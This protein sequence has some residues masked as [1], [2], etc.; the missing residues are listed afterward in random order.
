VRLDPAEIPAL[1]LPAALVDRYQ[2]VIARTPE[3]RGAAPGTLSYHAGEARLLVGA[4]EAAR[5]EQD[6]L[7]RRLLAELRAAGAELTPEPARCVAVLATSLELVAGHAPAAAGQGTT[8][9]VLELASAAIRARLPNS[10]LGVDGGPVDQEAPAPAQIAL[11][12]VQFAANAA[13][14]EGARTLRLRIGIGPTFFVEWPSERTTSVPTAG[15]HHSRLRQRWGLG[16]VRMVAD[17]LGATALPPAPTEPGW[18]GACLSLGSRRLTLPLAQ[19]VGGAVRRATQ[20]WEQEAA[21]EVPE[22][23]EVLVRD[24]G[25][26]LAAAAGAPGTIARGELFAARCAGGA[27]W[28][29]L[30]PE[31]GAERARD[32]LR[33]LDHERA[34]WDLP[35]A[36]AIRVHALISLLGT[37][38]GEP[39]AA[40]APAAFE[41]DLPRACA[42][43]GVP[44][45]RVGPV[46][47]CPDPRVVAFLLGELGGELVADGAGMSLIPGAGAAANPLVRLLDPSFTGRVL[48][49]G[50]PR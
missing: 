29:A 35:E 38:L 2:E 1:P 39:P 28:V 36:R 46:L 13:G 21:V 6:A 23:R 44:P 40:F 48:L 41:R 26:V 37:S 9:E 42:A 47:A 8:G 20:T 11:A 18:A 33:G 15:R 45:P 50:T 34:L 27:T 43:L 7:T 17:A 14:H 31:T 12:L 5:P 49:A 19:Y 22:L 3:W 10:A 4:G 16:Y 32:V 25:P 24:L 30:P